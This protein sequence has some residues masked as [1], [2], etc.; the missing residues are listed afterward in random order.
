MWFL[1]PEWGQSYHHVIPESRARLVLS[2]CDSW[3]QSEA[4]PI[5]MWFLIPEWV[6][7][8][9]YVISDPRMS[10][11]LPSLAS[12]IQNEAGPNITWLVGPI[13]VEALTT[14]NWFQMVLEFLRVIY[15]PNET[16]RLR[17]KCPDSCPASPLCDVASWR[18]VSMATHV[19]LLM[20][21]KWLRFTNCYWN[22]QSEWKLFTGCFVWY[23]Y[24]KYNV[25]YFN[26]EVVEI[27]TEFRVLINLRT[28]HLFLYVQPLYSL[29]CLYLCYFF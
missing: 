16:S 2:S 23:L 7:S 27:D 4:S 19:L 12:S 25:S 21:H 6:W 8:C 10:L 28:K 14:G 26:S 5:I 11:V 20:Q 29:W 9:H 1:I 22:V 24:P 18:P 3:L 17:R 15:A 13:Q